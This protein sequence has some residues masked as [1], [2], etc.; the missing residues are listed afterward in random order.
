M[1]TATTGPTSKARGPAG[2][3]RCGVLG[4]FLPV[5][6]VGVPG[7]AQLAGIDETTGAV[8][9][10]GRVSLSCERI[11][12]GA[13]VERA[14]QDL[15][16]F[17][18]TYLLVDASAPDGLTKVVAEQPS[19]DTWSAE[20][21]EGTPPV[22]YSL[23]DFPAPISR[24]LALPNRDIK[25]LFGVLEHPH[26]TPAPEAAMLTVTAALDT[27]YAANE[28]LSLYVI[29]TWAIRGFVGAEL[30]AVGASQLGP[31]PFAYSSMTSVTGRPLDKITTADAPLVL[32]HVGND[33][34]GYVPPVGF[35]QS[36][37]SPIT[38]TMLPNPHD[39]VL[40]VR[41]DP[42]AVAG[43]YAPAR[44]AVTNIA[45]SWA[46]AAAPGHE[47]AS[48]SGPTLQA[49]GV[50]S[51]DNGVLSVP[52]G[53]PFVA[54]GWKTVMVWATSASR[55]FTPAGQMLP[56]TLSASLF[57]VVYPTAGLVLD[58]PAP[59]PEAITLDG[60]PLSTDGMMMTK[61]SRAVSASF[62]VATP[63]TLS[64]MQLLDIVPNTANT[65]LALQNVLSESSTTSEFF[66]PAE[67]LEVGHRY[68]LR[69]LCIV[70]GYP[71][72]AEG[73]LTH[74][75]LPLALGAFDS[76]VFTVTAP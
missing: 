21:A 75:D 35:D 47:I 29:G 42:A 15:T 9:P 59:L 11:S 45:M 67:R 7:C 55:A 46:L 50:T 72:I 31:V 33:L 41:L 8:N 69:M 44:P 10:P 27:P 19:L 56:V 52:Y 49:A 63:C 1:G 57:Q 16:G 13:T 26:P 2:M 61:P 58:L 53:N 32:R 68:T 24:V 43:R 20:I 65:G 51:A 22:A 28:S 39:Q 62:L 60:K 30:P 25:D 23:P 36:T 34:T 18:A 5:L 4:R 38:G 17:T 40:D 6:L 54:M 14:A 70:G 64:H 71:T 12:V 3:L 48:G 76:G 74:R 37:V 73:D 66:I